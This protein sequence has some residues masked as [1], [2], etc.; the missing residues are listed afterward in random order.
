[1]AYREK[2]KPYILKYKALV[3]KCALYF[4]AFQMLDNQHGFSGSFSLVLFARK[5][6]GTRF[7]GCV[8]FV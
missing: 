7:A 8:I 3:L 4:C 6:L 2:Y 1:M 5:R